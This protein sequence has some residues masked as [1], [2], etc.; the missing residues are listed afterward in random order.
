MAKDT[1]SITDNRTGKVY[2][3]PITDE[4]IRS[5]DLRQIKVNDDD[6]GL[7]AYDP[8]YQNTAACRSSI[9]YINGEKGI[10]TYRGYSIEDLARDGTFLEVAYLLLNG[11]LPNAAES[12][13]WKH[14][15][16]KSWKHENM[17]TW[18]HGNMKT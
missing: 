18:K 12:E 1:L 7:M 6:F 5:L 13:A 14:E 9:T 11:E 10:L 17:E 16:M 2:E 3:I 8:A 4:T 15:S